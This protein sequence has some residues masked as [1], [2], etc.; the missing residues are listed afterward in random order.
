VETFVSI[1]GIMT[2]DELRQELRKRI[3]T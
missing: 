3:G 2:E 1:T